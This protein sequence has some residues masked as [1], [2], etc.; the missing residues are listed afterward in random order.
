MADTYQRFTITSDR[1]LLQ[2]FGVYLSNCTQAHS[3]VQQ[4][5]VIIKNEE[6]NPYQLTLILTLIP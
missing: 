2:N 6:R 3:R 1:F 5:S 4:Y